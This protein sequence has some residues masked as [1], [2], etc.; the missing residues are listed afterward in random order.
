MVIGPYEDDEETGR[1]LDET[2]NARMLFLIGASVLV[3]CSSLP[4]EASRGCSTCYELVGKWI[5]F[6]DPS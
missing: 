3:N 6:P 4:M 2:G 1:D 5:K